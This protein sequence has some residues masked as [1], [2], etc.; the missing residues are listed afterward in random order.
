M[1]VPA[2]LTAKQRDLLEQYAR[3]ENGA[4]TPLVQGFWEKVKSLF[5]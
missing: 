4:G 2:H 1:E 3:L 5:D